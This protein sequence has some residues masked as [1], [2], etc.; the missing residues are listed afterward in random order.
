MQ[1]GK[2]LGLLA[3]I[4]AFLLVSRYGCFYAQKQYDTVR[5][6]WA[7]SNDAAQPLLVGAWQGTCTDADG[8][9]HQV[10]LEIFEPLSDENAGREWANRTKNAVAAAPLFLMV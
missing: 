7:Y 2:T 10:S 4:I 6:P 3:G 5:R 1:K 8:V 9:A